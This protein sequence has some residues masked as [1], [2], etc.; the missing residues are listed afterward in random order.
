MN[1]LTPVL[2]L[3]AVAWLF[4]SAGSASAQPFPLSAPNYGVGYRPALSP[5]LNLLRGGDP[6]AN[7]FIGTVPEQ[8]RRQNTRLF[9]SALIEMDQ[10]VTNLTQEL[11]L[12]VPITSTG[13]ITAFGNTG[14]YFATNH[15]VTPASRAITAPGKPKQ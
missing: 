3:A 8:D 10:R 13:H 4:S 9:S 14:N 2:L 1:R 6:A 12:S 7:Y 11:D 15:V 5:Y